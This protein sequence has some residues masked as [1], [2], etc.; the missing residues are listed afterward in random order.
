MWSQRFFVEGFHLLPAVPVQSIGDDRDVTV[1]HPVE[2][3]SD[4]RVADR[5]DD[6][7]AGGQ[8]DAITYW[9]AQLRPHL[10]MEVLLRDATVEMLGRA[11]D[12]LRIDQLDAVQLK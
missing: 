8:A 1:F 7:P 3:A 11:A 4:N 2:Y 9:M 12:L 5:A 10:V 6:S